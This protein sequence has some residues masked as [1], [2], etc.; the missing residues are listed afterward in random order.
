MMDQPDLRERWHSE[1]AN[2]PAEHLGLVTRKEALDLLNA[3]RAARGRAYAPYSKLAVG[4][5][6]LCEDR[7]LFVGANVENASYSATIC[8]ERVAIF[9][10]VN[11]GCLAFI[12]VAVVADFPRP[13]PPCGLCRQVLAEF[14]RRTPI[15]MANLSGDIS[16]RGID[17][18]LP[19][20]FELDGLNKG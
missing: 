8:A 16:L 2:A 10:A 13:I 3:A 14:T 19:L 11:A 6:V 7:S 17:E 20:A 15:I 12:A 18:L 4:A 1:L 9:S 5:A